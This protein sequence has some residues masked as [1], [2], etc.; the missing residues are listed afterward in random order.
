MANTSVSRRLSLLIGCLGIFLISV[1]PVSATGPISYQYSYGGDGNTYT[2]YF[3]QNSYPY[4]IYI[5]WQITVG[6]RDRMESCTEP[7]FQIQYY[8]NGTATQSIVYEAFHNSTRS[9]CFLLPA[10][11]GICVTV[12]TGHWHHRYY[13]N[14][15]YH[16]DYGGFDCSYTITYQPDEVAP[17]SPGIPAIIDNGDGHVYQSAGISYTNYQPVPLTWKAAQDNPSIYNGV[18]IKSDIKEYILDI[19]NLEQSQTYGTNQ[20]SLA[21]LAQGENKIKVKARDKAGNIGSF[22]E[23]LTLFVDQIAPS[24][25]GAPTTVNQNGYTHAANLTWTW[26]ASSDTTPGSG[27]K[28]Y[29][30]YVVKDDGTVAVDWVSTTTNSYSQ[31]SIDGAGYTCKVRAIDNVG[32]L[33]YESIPVTVKVDRSVPQVSLTEYP[34]HQSGNQLSL[35]WN[36]VIDTGSGLKNY[37]VALTSTAIAPDDTQAQVLENTTTS[38]TQY[39]FATKINSK[40]KYYAWVRGIDQ[41]GNRGV[42]QGTVAFPKYSITGPAN[43]EYIGSKLTVGIHSTD[44]VSLKFRAGYQLSGD[45]STVQYSNYDTSTVTVNL[46]QGTWKWWL[47]IYEGNDAAPQI[48]ESFKVT[49]D[50]TPPPSESNTFVIKATS[51]GQIYDT[52]NYPTNIR[53]VSITNLNLID[54]PG[55]SGIKGIYLWNGTETTPPVNATYKALADISTAIP[56]TLA[57]GEDGI[58]T[59]TMQVVD[60]AG[61]STLVTYQVLLDTTLPAALDPKKITHTTTDSQIAFQWQA[62]DAGNDIA[63]FQ[64]Q[65]TLPDGTV[66][67]FQVTAS[68]DGNNTATGSLTVPVSGYGPNQPV[69]LTVASVDKAGNQSTPASYTAYTKAALGSLQNLDGGYDP[70]L[71]QFYLSWQISDT[72]S[73]GADK[74]ILE[75]GTQDTNTETFT[76]Q[77]TL[78]P[79]SGIFT[80]SG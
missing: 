19:N 11:T 7:R 50:T 65:Y 31:E 21:T 13:H 3:L 69:V 58:R 55:G 77:A 54:N 20:C 1:L 22:S 60:N 66:K 43:G 6:D 10:N 45:N 33:S 34:L 64:G 16:N 2:N 73:T 80:H 36:T 28:G 76:V 61:N 17:N 71:Q 27:L 68:N 63:Q 40:G 37:E 15:S 25:P 62:S 49:V 56:W 57:D 42:W 74:Y 53:N 78:S 9:G 8:S 59:V 67:E 52:T 29:Q 75:Y 38:A 24:I 23:E 14:L 70:N 47:E 44:S 48:T 32:N 26:D 46:T 5:W 35:S 39:T 41:L 51:G 12:Y 72:V 18:E 4:S 79:V 30:V